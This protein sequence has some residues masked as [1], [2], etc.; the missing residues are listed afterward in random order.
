MKIH[1]YGNQNANLV[2]LQPIGD[3]DL[4]SL[5]HELSSLTELAGRDFRWIGFQ[6]EDWNRELSPWEAPAV[7]GQDDFGD[8]AQDTL[9]EI[10]K[11][12][13]DQNKTYC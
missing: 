11:Y 2:L 7:F 4:S 3:H 13:D 1:E 5:E 12:C 9:N 10:M 8:G 6:V